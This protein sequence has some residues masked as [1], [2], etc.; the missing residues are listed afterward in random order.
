MPDSGDYSIAV[1]AE[2]TRI[3]KQRKNSRGK[4]KDVMLGMDALPKAILLRPDDEKCTLRRQDRCMNDYWQEGVDR[5]TSRHQEQSRKVPAPWRPVPPERPMDLELV[6]NAESMAK[7][8]K[9][10]GDAPGVFPNYTGLPGQTNE[11]QRRAIRL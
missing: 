4:L 11:E 3:A 6:Q 10:F 1:E 5:I 7:Y 8:Q 9:K 2:S